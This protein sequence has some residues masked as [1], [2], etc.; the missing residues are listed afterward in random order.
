MAYRSYRY[1][2]R[3]IRRTARKSKRNFIISLILVI[4]L[5]YF[6]LLWILPN[7]IGILGSIKEFV[8]PPPIKDASLKD[9]TVSLAP[10]IFN[11]PFEATNTAQIDIQGYATPQT[12]VLIYLD[13]KLFETINTA[14]DGSFMAKNIS[15]SLGTNNIFGKTKGPDEKESLTSKTIKVIFDNEKPP[16]EIFEP[17]D[18]KEI[19]GERKLKIAGK[20]ETNSQVFINN[21]QVIVDQEGRFESIQNLND[22][23]NIFNIKAIDA[24]SNFTEVSRRVNF[25]P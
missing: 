19:L 25:T 16:L 2:R 21:N 4:V 11:I 3:A 14:G 24:A 13:D 15:L 8:N 18:G 6:A 22:S 20:T 1:S 12:Q 10:P 17:E 23:D 9:S 7:F 5:V